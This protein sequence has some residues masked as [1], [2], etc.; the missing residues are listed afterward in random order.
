ML[1]I[2]AAFGIGVVVPLELDAGCR[3]KLGGL[4]FVDGQIQCD[5]AIAPAG[6]SEG[7]SVGPACGVCF[8]PQVYWL[9]L[10]TVSL[11]MGF[12]TSLSP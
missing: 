12:I 10:M 5:N 6:I 9:Q 3:S 8:P 4:A 2:I 11:N 7:V 1:L